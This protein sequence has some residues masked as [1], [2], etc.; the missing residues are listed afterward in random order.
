MANSFL[1]ASATPCH[2]FQTSQSSIN[3]IADSSTEAMGR[4]TGLVVS[5]LLLLLVALLA[6]QARGH[7]LRPF[8]KHMPAGEPDW[9]ALQGSFAVR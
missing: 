8:G 1:S 5:L 2:S 4:P 9:K 3:G 7:G 6:A